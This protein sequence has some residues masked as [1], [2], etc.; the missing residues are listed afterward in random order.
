DGVGVLGL[1]KAPVPDLVRV[2]DARAQPRAEMPLHVGREASDEV[3]VIVDRHVEMGVG[4]RTVRE[5]DERLDRVTS[6][7]GAE[8][9]VLVVEVLASSLKARLIRR[10]P[11]GPVPRHQ[12]DATSWA[13]AARDR[14]TLAAV[15]AAT[16]ALAGRVRLHPI[17]EAQAAKRPQEG[18]HL[19]RKDLALV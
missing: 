7:F 13:I 11:L 16:A 19:R 10:G 9:G 14:V 3:V 2:L 1:R 17:H 5:R 18:E 6:N 4:A 8:L 15:L 12:A